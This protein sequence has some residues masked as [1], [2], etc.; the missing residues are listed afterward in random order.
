[1]NKCSSCGKEF[2]EPTLK[3]MIHIIGRKA[4]TKKVCPSCQSIVLNNPNYY[5]LADEKESK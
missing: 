4:Y 3:T 2:P 1:M 5:Y